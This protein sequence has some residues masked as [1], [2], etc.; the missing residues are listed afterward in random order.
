[1]SNLPMPNSTRLPLALLLAG[2]GCLG[3]ALGWGANTNPTVTFQTNSTNATNLVGK[4]FSLRL[5]SLSA[6]TNQANRLINITNFST[7]GTNVTLQTFSND[8]VSFQANFTNPAA[9]ADL[10]TTNGIN[11]LRFDSTNGLLYGIPTN[12]FILSL[13]NG[14]IEV[15]A[16]NRSWTVTNTFSN[17]V[18]RLSETSTIVTNLFTNTA[19]TNPAY[20]LVF[21][22]T[23]AMSFTNTSMAANAT[24]ALP[25]TNANAL[26]NT[27][28]VLSGPGYLTNA[29]DL[30]ATNAGTIL[31][32]LAITPGTNGTNATWRA[33]TNTYA[34]VATNP[35]AAG[36]AFVTNTNAASFT[37]TQL[38]Y[39]GITPLVLTNQ[40]SA[41]VTF[42]LSR[43]AAGRFFVSNGV[44]N[45]QALS[46]VSNLVITAT[47]AATATSAP[48]TA[49]LTSTLSRASNPITMAGVFSNTATNTVTNPATT[50]LALLGTASHGIVVFASTNTGLVQIT[51]GRTLRLLANG[52]STVVASVTNAN[53]N[54]YLPADPVTNTVIVD[55]SSP[56]APVF[57]STNRQDGAVGAAFS[58]TLAATA[59]NT[60]AFPITY[61]ATNLPDGLA[62][63]NGNQISGSPTQA[64]LYRV[65]LTAS[66]GGGVATHIL[67]SLIAPS[68]AFSVTNL[69]TNR[70]ALG[71][72]TNTNGS[73]TV[74]N[75]PAGIGTNTTNP[76]GF[77]QPVLLLANTNTN[78]GTSGWF[79][80]MTNLTVVFSNSQTN[81]TSTV[82]LNVRPVVPALSLPS[83]VTGT[84]GI[85]LS[86]TGAPTPSPLTNIPGYP[87]F[88]RSTNLPQGLVLNP[89]SGVISGKPVFAGSNT[90]SIWVSNAVG[91][92][93]TSSVGFNIQALAGAPVRLSVA[94]TNA[95][96]TYA[97]PN[98]PPGLTLAPST[99]LVTGSPQAVGTLLLTVNFVPTGTATTNT[100]QQTLVILPPAPVPK[101]PASLVTAQV[102]RPFHLQPWVTGPGWGWAGA[103]TLTG[104]TI[105]TNWTN[106]IL[107][108]TSTVVLASNSNGVIRPTTNGL[109]F[110]NNASY[111]ELY[112]LWRSNLP[113]SWPWQAFLRLRIPGSLTHADGYAYPVLG[114]IRARTAYP[115]NYLD[116]YADGGLLAESTN[117]VFPTSFFYSPN[118]TNSSFLDTVGTNEVAI[119]FRFDTNGQILTIAANTNLATNVHVGLTTNT[120]LAVDWSLS[121]AASAF[122]LALGGSFSNQAVASNQILL[123]SFAVL[124]QGVGF[125]TSTNLPGGLVCDPETGTIYGTPTNAFSGLI[126]LYAT[127][128]Q[129]TNF[130]GFR[131]RVIP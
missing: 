126:Y 107:V 103:D 37:A 101:V 97:V 42:A 10:G 78:P 86:V 127:N 77:T 131:L 104:T 108:G 46:G 3:P 36:F 119:R 30:V 62:F 51:N 9:A 45:L 59:T 99:G 25:V 2:V 54:N 84:P 50:S 106:Q 95:A 122:R 32:R 93:A 34:V 33:V 91:G 68:P 16:T 71:S 125:Y 31:L 7:N 92:S 80:G 81:V 43:P 55:W 26:T 38:T 83:N 102:G 118:A 65:T 4:Y 115:T 82:S 112:L 73:Y 12:N 56:A 13:S 60:N 87:L 79:A 105:S 128:A 85:L 113:S 123:R 109:T 39:L 58:Y 70:V 14:G 44:T 130:T 53:T 48:T 114:A 117:G 8:L 29:T 100:N 21:Q 66:N 90:A 57:T 49:L 6:Y 24:N 75:L 1:M 15:I 17:N 19:S 72:G 40:G 98:L 63:T 116:D 94:F 27:Y 61:A 111:N 124:P 20:R 35:L 88:F 89:T 120:N 69:W 18:L 52:T 96:G 129:G 28:T 110:T 5:Y 22:A 47:R 74:S 11:G 64:G 23:P 76:V 121:N 67:T 41:R